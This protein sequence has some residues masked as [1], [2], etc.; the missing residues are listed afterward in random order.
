MRSRFVTLTI[1]FPFAE[2]ID[3]CG[4]MPLASLPRG[5]TRGPIV[6]EARET[7]LRK[8]T[9]II[10]RNVERTWNESS[11]HRSRVSRS[12]RSRVSVDNQFRIHARF[13]RGSFT[14]L[15]F[16][17]Q[18]NTRP[19]L[20]RRRMLLRNV[21]SESDVDIGADTFVYENITSN[22]SINRRFVKRRSF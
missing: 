15:C 7:Q 20:V 2:L 16:R 22:V 13:R 19:F 5:I 3:V 1:K 10:R 8:R 12:F 9:T 18:R 21:L 11:G 4:C 6:S 14:F 17:V